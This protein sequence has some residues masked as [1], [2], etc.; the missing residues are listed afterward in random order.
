MKEELR[1]A[2]KTHWNLHEEGCPSSSSPHCGPTHCRC[3]C[4]DR[5]RRLTCRALQHGRLI[6]SP[7]W[8]DGWMSQAWVIRF[9]HGN[10]N[11]SN[12]SCDTRQMDLSCSTP[13]AEP[14]TIT[15]RNNRQADKRKHGM[16]YAYLKGVGVE[17]QPQCVSVIPAAQGVTHHSYVFKIRQVRVHLKQEHGAMI[18]L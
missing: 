3:S 9:C 12:I 8:R 13:Q 7:R 5:G 4:P 15:Q 2:S 18:H 16:P 6:H 11:A 17:A 14:N 1:G 10:E